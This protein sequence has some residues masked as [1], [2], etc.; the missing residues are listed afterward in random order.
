MKTKALHKLFIH[1]AGYIKLMH[2][3]LLDCRLARLILLPW[4]PN[5]DGIGTPHANPGGLVSIGAPSTPFYS[6]GERWRPLAFANGLYVC[7]DTDDLPPAAVTP[8]QIAYIQNMQML[9]ISDS[10]RWQALQAYPLTVL[11]PPDP[12]QP[13]PNKAA[14]N[15][16]GKDT[17]PIRC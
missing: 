8:G 12:N 6:D 1:A 4:R 5:M 15:A 16:Q 7:Q 14:I 13:K 17:D 3:A 2:Q 10:E 9:A 11:Q